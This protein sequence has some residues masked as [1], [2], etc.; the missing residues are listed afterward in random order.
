V[1]QKGLGGDISGK[2]KKSERVLISPE[3]L[4]LKVDLAPR[5]ERVASLLMDWMLIIAADLLLVM[6]P[7]YLGLLDSITAMTG[8]WFVAF[9]VNNLYF[10]FFELKD[11]G[12]T[13]G[14]KA[15]RLQVI[16][17]K[18]G[19][20]SPYAIVARNI[21]RQL[22]LFMPLLILSDRDFH[23]FWSLILP[24]GWL[25]G[26]TLLPFWNK[27]RLRMGDILA[28][29]IVIS[30][31]KKVLLPELATQVKAQAPAFSFTREQLSIYGNYE[32][33]IL[34]EMLR[35][36][37]S[38]RR[39]KALRPVALKISRKIGANLSPKL[40]S[41]EYL[42]FLK[43][44]YAAERKELEEGKLYGRIKANKFAPVLQMGGRG[45]Q[46]APFAGGQPMNPA[47][48][49]SYEANALNPKKKRGGKGKGG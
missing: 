22:E 6:V 33:Q 5:G 17:R 49:P 35:R 37:S 41:E 2:P 34:E 8:F 25:F 10:I 14:K 42:K 26:V 13:P 43:D 4:P 23:V 44:F 9:I 48:G 30:T 11:Q 1:L 24:I 45:H 38:G 40:A 29:T 27:D 32:L 46:G 7:A 19:E 18:G 20:L 21:V 15:N 12:R 47:A 16:N 39:I 36:N 28:G 3:G 31:P